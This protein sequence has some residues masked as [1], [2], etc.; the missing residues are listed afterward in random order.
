MRRNSQIS[1]AIVSLF[2]SVKA[3]LIIL[4]REC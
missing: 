4:E 2:Y 1:R 3:L